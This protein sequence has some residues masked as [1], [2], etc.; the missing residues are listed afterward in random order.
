MI[1]IEEIDMSTSFRK[2][3][4]ALFVTKSNF[5]TTWY[6]DKTVRNIYIYIKKKHTV[7]VI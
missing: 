4:V 2:L 1:F 7:Y 6:D 3:L 5:V